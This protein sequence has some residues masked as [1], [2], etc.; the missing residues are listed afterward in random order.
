M[1]K[2]DK[3]GRYS[4]I[5]K[6]GSGGMGEVFLARDKQLDRNIAVKILLDEFSADDER[7]KRFK[8][9]A[10]AVSALNHPGILTIY[11]IVEDAGKLFIATE[12][13]DGVTLRRFS[14]SRD[15]STFEAVYIAEQIADALEAAHKMEIVHRDIKP[16]NIMVRQDGY[17]KILDFGLA[18][19]TIL[20]DAK[21][22]NQTIELVRT[23][24]GL[25]MGSV[26]YMSPEQAR[27]KQ[28]DKRTDIWSLGVVLFEMLAK[29]NPFDGETVSD[30]LAAL[31]R[32]DPDIATKIPEDIQPV[33]YRALAKDVDDRY[34]SI[35]EMAAELKHLRVQI[36]RESLSD[37]DAISNTN[38]IPTRISAETKKLVNQTA[39]GEPTVRMEQNVTRGNSAAA[40]PNKLYIAL[41]LLAVLAVGAFGGWFFYSNFSGRNA[42]E[43]ESIKVSL[44]TTDG[45]A[46]AAAVSPDGK[47]AAYVDTSKGDPRLVLR[48]IATGSN[49]EVVPPIAASFMQ[50]TFSPDGEFIYYVIVIKAVGSLYRVST[51]GGEPQKLLVDI[52]SAVSFS[53]NGDEFAFI[54]HD[55]SDGGDTI[56]IASKDGAKETEF[57]KTSEVSFD[58]F[59]T[60]VW[61]DQPDSIVFSGFRSAD[62]RVRNVVL[63]AISR[64]TKKTVETPE[65][66][67]LNAGEW[68]GIRAVNWLRD[69]SGMIF[70]GERA[71]DQN[72]QIWR[73]DFGNVIQTVTT[74][75]SD[76]ASLS[77]SADQKVMIADK[78]DRITGLT[79]YNLN[80]RETGVVIPEN[81]NFQGQMG[82][83]ELPNGRILYS[84]LDGDAL[85]I[86]SIKKDGTD[87]KQLTKSGKMNIQPSPTID[88][89]QI[90]FASD[91][92]GGRSVWIMDSDG[93]NPRRITNA[94]NVRDISPKVLAD[95]KTVLFVRQGNDGGKSTIFK[96]TINGG[97]AE[98]IL[99]ES[100]ATRFN[101][102]VSPDGSRIAYLVYDYDKNAQDLVFSVRI[103]KF[104]NG[105]AVGE[106]EEIKSEINRTFRWSPDGKSLAYI[107]KEG[108]DNIYEHSF[109]SQTERRIT[110]F[111]SGAIMSFNWSNNGKSLLLVRGITNS[112]LVLIKSAV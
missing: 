18:K 59:S 75:T 15:I 63:L 54:R 100:R 32:K 26:K 50:P 33:L 101:L 86:Y 83:S 44:M 38:S 16:E 43:T 25:V 5:R 11:E 1:Q 69:G 82:I 67:K 46:R 102:E 61:T 30:S 108:F 12:F 17:V 19:P 55:S 34:A 103:T 105:V 56:L 35:S 79:E 88:G 21:S 64:K 70:V 77:V 41:I 81:R 84:K 97:E 110:D 52:D 73:Y 93:S 71:A 29:E 14:E 20:G 91:R 48:Q 92:E 85:N 27:G 87:E 96:T 106:P 66:A 39:S 76:Y 3:L 6:I 47:F 94:P 10:K 4:V 104:E 24:P 95:G 31:I 37:V 98:P 109:Q 57:V 78:V 111:N 62:E 89:R 51:L 9:E 45:N 13:V 8:Y 2:G 80:T 58:R 60:V 36:E 107:K 90:L 28:T 72:R 68:Q 112:D 53:P 22:V 99:P 49:L 65:L 74:D 7:V 23:Q 42:S 40:S